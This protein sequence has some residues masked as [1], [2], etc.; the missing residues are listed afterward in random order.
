VARPTPWACHQAWS[1]PERFVNSAQRRVAL[2]FHHP[3]D[4]REAH[5]VR[6]PRF[7]PSCHLVECLIHIYGADVHA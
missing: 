7:D 1:N 4:A 6:A 3:V 2:R 5:V